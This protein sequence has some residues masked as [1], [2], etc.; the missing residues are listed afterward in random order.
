MGLSFECKHASKR[1]NKGS[2]QASKQNFITSNA[3]HS[4]SAISTAFQCKP[5]QLLPKARQQHIK[6]ASPLTIIPLL[7]VK[8]KSLRSKPFQMRARGIM[9]FEKPQNEDMMNGRDARRKN[10]LEKSSK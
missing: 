2:N 10:S 7:S 8:M 9:V 1:A 4:Q 6:L 5:T 3:R